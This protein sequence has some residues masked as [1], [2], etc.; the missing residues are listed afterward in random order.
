M[1]P[2]NDTTDAMRPRLRGSVFITPARDGGGAVVTDGVDMVTLQG[3][4]TYAWLE[5]LVPYLDGQHTVGDL[6]GALPADRRRA[7]RNLVTALR[8]AR[9]LRDVAADEPH[10]LTTDETRTYAA[11]IALIEA[12]E[13]SPALRFERFRT[14][15]VV[16]IGAGRIVTALAHS[17]LSCGS[18]HVTV[19]VT[20]ECPTATG[21]FSALAADRAAR[22]RR[23][24]LTWRS[25][26]D[27]ATDELAGAVGDAEVV[28]HASDRP[29]LERAA[30]V[31]GS[32]IGRF[33][34]QVLITGNSA[35][36]GPVC[37]PEPSAVRGSDVAA[38]LRAG[39]HPPDE[40]VAP[41]VLIGP[42]PGIVANHAAFA[43]FEYL[44]GVAGAEAA[45]RVVHIDL[46]TL[47]TA[48]HRLP[49]GAPGLTT[50][51]TAGR[52]EDRVAALE[53]GPELTGVRDRLAALTDERLGILRSLGPEDADQLPLRIGCA[54]PAVA[55]RPAVWAAAADEETADVL[56]GLA[57]VARYASCSLGASTVAG[58][59]LAD[60]TV[61]QVPVRL[62]TADAGTAGA[63]TWAGAVQAG[64][65]AHCARLA[66]QADVDD[67]PVNLAE[68][69]DDECDRLLEL[70]VAA[71]RPVTLHDLSG[72]LAVPTVA[73]RDATGTVSCRAAPNAAAAT[74]AA[75]TDALFRCQT[76]G[77]R[78]ARVNQA[79]ATGQPDVRRELV[80]ALRRA[81]H[82]PVVV[83]LDHE[84]VLRH[85]L[86]YLA[87]VVMM[88]SDAHR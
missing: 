9:F 58:L 20:G 37:G 14:A 38:R 48:T 4:T 22:D 10:G 16:I 83:P 7:V 35:Y 80:T 52:V 45:G 76:G 55:G 49:I 12:F 19:L 82:H 66:S 69:S 78:H 65:L 70:L 56:A 54:M 34:A 51:V 32:A 42:V 61:H 29:M 5:R 41:N 3:A 11:E 13:D 2:G 26:P 57:G 60:H 21:E 79:A 40:P 50:A 18:A 74:R 23:Q 77:T 31:D 27:P 53:R 73:V 6:T 67:Q 17:M 71:G 24:R 46:E 39:G 44:T 33:S 30:A 43:V 1:R 86:P 87:A 63:T 85:T 68:V 62:L 25:C 47:D 72:A 64:L 36:V 15:R 59:S 75:L 28:L 88:D 81:G 84:P 8:S